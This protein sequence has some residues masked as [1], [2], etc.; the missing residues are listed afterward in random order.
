MV[1]KHSRKSRKKPGHHDH[2][3]LRRRGHGNKGG[4][5]R[6]G[7][8]KRSKQKK[9]KFMKNGKVSMGKHGFTS[10]HEKVETIDVGTLSEKAN[11]L[12]EK[13]ANKWVIDLKQKKV[14][15]SGTVKVPLII[16]NFSSITE[17]A[18]NKITKAG[19]EIVEK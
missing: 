18:K 7:M 9:H 15:G 13:K 12:G 4:F 10:I 5:G 16:S 19:G 6:S 2:D 17:K 3:G 8:G 11:F 14:L 1:V